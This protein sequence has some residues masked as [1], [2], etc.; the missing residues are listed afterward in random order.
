MKEKNDKKYCKDL[1]HNA[2]GHNANKNVIKKPKPYPTSKVVEG[3]KN[4][5]IKKYRKKIRPKK[6]KIPPKHKNCQKNRKI[7]TE[8]NTSFQKKV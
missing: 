1:E 5:M 7:Q 6:S 4:V 2:R 3:K 8:K